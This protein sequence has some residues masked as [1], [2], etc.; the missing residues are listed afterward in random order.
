MGVKL[1]KLKK[2]PKCGCKLTNSEFYMD[3]TQA[4]NLSIHCKKCIEKYFQQY[5]IKK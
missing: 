3:V 1:K 2:C 5:M 4:D